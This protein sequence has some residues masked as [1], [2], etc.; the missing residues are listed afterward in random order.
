MDLKTYL[1]ELEYLVNIDSG[2]ETIE[3]V[4]KVADFFA[5]RFK[6]LGWTVRVEDLAPDA[7]PCVICAN[8]EA[9]HYDVMLIGHMDTVFLKGTCAQRPFR[10]MMRDRLSAQRH[11]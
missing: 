6:G 9:E 2:T 5:D 1:S 4:A 8:R 11:K 10:M 3:G 7:G